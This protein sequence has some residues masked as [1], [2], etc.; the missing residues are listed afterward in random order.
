MKKYW[1]VKEK[2]VIRWIVGVTSVKICKQ[3]QTG[4]DTK[5]IYRKKK[6]KEKVGQKKLMDIRLN[7]IARYVII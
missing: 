5:K 4:M 2:T 3:K 6:K 7:A 1:E